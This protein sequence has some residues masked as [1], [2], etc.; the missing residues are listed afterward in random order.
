MNFKLSSAVLALFFYVAAVA[1][2]DD[3][4]LCKKILDKDVPS[5]KDIT[6]YKTVVTRL[7]GA[8][9]SLTEGDQVYVNFYEGI[10]PILEMSLP[11][12]ANNPLNFLSN[13]SPQ[14]M[15]AMVQTANAV[16]DYEK[17]IGKELH[18]ADI[19]EMYL[20]FKPILTNV[21][22][23]LGKVKQYVLAAGLFNAVY[24][25]DTKDQDNLF[26]AASYAVNGSDYA[27]ALKYYYKLKDLNY[28]GEGMV[29]FAKNKA[30]GVEESFTTKKDRDQYV[31]LGSHLAPRDEAIPSRRGEIFK[32]IAL[33]LVNEGKI[34]EAK[35]AISDARAVNPSDQ[36]LM[37]EE[38]NLY[39]KLSDYDNYK[40]IVNEL[41]EKDPNNADLVYNL[42]VITA[43]TDKVA[44]ETYYKRAIEINPS[45]TN[46]YLNLAILKLEPEKQ[47][48][49][50]MNKLGTSEKDNK[51]YEVLK[52]QREAIFRS[53]LP[54][55]EKAQE[56][57]PANEQVYQT[58]YNVYGALEMESERKLLKQR[59]GK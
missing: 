8:Y 28:S 40:K 43:N 11:E 52:A 45:Y 16:I 13:L 42:A 49:D 12:N 31:K 47:I 9:A 26:Y 30:T 58:L 48:I 51:K 37:L 18:T 32:N 27:N 6:E 22:I 56:L 25:M 1:Q 34:D 17:K 59:A 2:K 54:Y 7:R 41:L 14:K 44:A 46:A 36:S 24:E 21:A 3:L 53:T 4:K 35:I 55:L 15:I 39:L 23:E 29:F 50:E 19:K 33:I 10:M 5:A 20:A 57:D 38:A